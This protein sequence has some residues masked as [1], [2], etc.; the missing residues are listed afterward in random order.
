VHE[1]IDLTKIVPNS[2]GKVKQFTV[3]IQI[4]LVAFNSIL[5]FTGDFNNLSQGF[6]PAP[7]EAER[8]SALSQL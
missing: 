3:D 8:N 5:E 7:H 6:R 2:E 4:D 1:N